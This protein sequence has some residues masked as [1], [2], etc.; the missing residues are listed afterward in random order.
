MVFGALL[1]AQDGVQIESSWDRA[2]EGYLALSASTHHYRMLKKWASVDRKGVYGLMG[3]V[4]RNRDVE[5]LLGDA[6][7]AQAADVFSSSAADQLRK[8][9]FQDDRGKAHVMLVKHLVQADL[10]PQE[11]DARLLKVPK[12][13]LQKQMHSVSQGLDHFQDSPT[14]M[15]GTRAI[16]QACNVPHNGKYTPEELDGACISLILGLATRKELQKSHG[17]SARTICGT[18]AKIYKAI[19]TPGESHNDA[20]TRTREMTAEGIRAVLQGM[21]MRGELKVHFGIE[22]NNAR[23]LNSYAKEIYTH[24]L[25]CS[26]EN[27]ANIFA[28]HVFDPNTR[29]HRGPLALSSSFL[30]C[31]W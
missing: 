14:S 6:E 22:K 7:Y 17:P 10:K 21:R 24:F 2:Y 8:R 25:L 12:A 18:V 23:L 30:S 11:M 9:K 15:A 26:N 3:H 28:T 20:R 31:A 16:H 27:A 13:K 29:T 5:N 1:S 19:A 4:Q